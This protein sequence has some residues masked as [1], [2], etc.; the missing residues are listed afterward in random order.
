MSSVNIEPGFQLKVLQA[1]NG[2]DEKEKNCCLIFDSMAIKQQI[3]WSGEKHKY[4]GFCDYGNAVSLKNNDVEAKEALVFLLVS[5]KRAWKWPIAYFLVNKTSLA[6]LCQLIKNVLILCREYNL[7]VHSVT[8]DGDACNCSA[9]NMLGAEIFTEDYRQIKNSFPCSSDENRNIKIILDPCHIVKLTRNALAD[10]KE[11]K[12]DKGSIKWDY[13]VKLHT[14]Q[15]QLTLKLKNHLSSQCINWKQ[16]KMKVKYAVHVLS[17]SVAN[18][19]R[20]NVN[21]IF[22]S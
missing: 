20:I 6:I 7:R 21:R 19:N 16:N 13:I 22:R 18:A 9:I 4:I 5:L 1:L 15:K 14:L 12:T 2:L 17:S 11:F 8:F 10:Y 3:T